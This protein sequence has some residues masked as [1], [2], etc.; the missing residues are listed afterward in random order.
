MQDPQGVPPRARAAAP[1]PGDGTA[2]ASVRDAMFAWL[3][4]ELPPGE[5]ARVAR[6]VRSCPACHRAAAHDRRL[7]A[8][9]RRAAGAPDR[10]SPALR[11]RV[12]DALDAAAPPDGPPPA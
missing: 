9:L 6:H 1:S 7:L 2:C 10:A 12:R 4:H 5:A 11:A 8:A 3:D